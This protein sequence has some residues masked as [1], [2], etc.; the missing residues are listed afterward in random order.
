VTTTSE[1]FVPAALRDLGP[2]RGT[3]PVVDVVYPCPQVGDP[4][5]EGIRARLLEVADGLEGVEVQPTAL[6]VP[7]DALVL[8]ERLAR[9][10][11]E[12]FIRGREF[13]IVRAEGSVHVSLDPV[14]GQRLLDMGWGTIHPLARYMAGV[15]PPQS[16]IVY[17][18]RDEGELDVVRSVLEAAHTFAVGR[19]GDL[20]LPDTAW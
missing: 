5:P 19:I 20:I 11:P 10:K 17:A 12:A 3:R 7:G 8:C 4:A 16:M 13:A 1:A 2:R 15:L 18:P 6:S 9:G 14:C